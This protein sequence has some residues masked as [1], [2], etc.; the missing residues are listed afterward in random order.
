MNYLS[1]NLK[2]LKVYNS[3]NELKR[4]QPKAAMGP[5]NRMRAIF[6]LDTPT[7]HSEQLYIPDTL[8]LYNL[9]IQ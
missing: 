1:T 7:E 9:L 6:V 2:S 4:R 8:L 5:V 3:I